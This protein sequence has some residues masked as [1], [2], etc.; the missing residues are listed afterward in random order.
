MQRKER[1]TLPFE[2]GGHADS[3]TGSVARRNRELRFTQIIVAAREAF[4]EDGYAGFTTRGVAGRVGI[5]LGNL[6]YY[7]RTKEELLRAALETYVREILDDYAAI[8]TRPGAVAARRCAA[9]V[10]RFLR[11]INETDLPRFLF[12]IWAFAQH[13]PFAA[14]LIDEWY[15]RY[16]SMFAGLLS[17]IHPSLTSE[18]CLT[19]AAVLVA[20]TNGMAIFAN[21]GAARDKDSAEFARMT[22][23]AVK[24]IVGLS[25]QALE[26]RPAAGRAR[27]RRPAHEGSAYANATDPKGQIEEAQF[28][29]TVRQDG[30]ERLYYR[31][32]VRGR[33]RE[34]KINE[35]VSTAANLLATEG[36]A[37][38]TQARV[39]RELGMLPSALQNY[40]PM[41]EDLLRSTIDAL[42]QVFLDRYA[43]M[44]KPS[45]K[46]ALERLREIVSDV[47]EEALDPQVCRF[48]FEFLAL[49]GHSETTRELVAH[50]YF[51]YRSIYVNLVREI[52]ASAT[53]RECIVRA[54]LIAAQ[55][56]GAATL[57]FGAKSQ[58]PN[59]DR[60]FELMIEMAARI[61]QGAVDAKTAL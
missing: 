11:D 32:T 4:Q 29:L 37:N 12:E 15:A 21:R 50:S 30:Q 55:M 26:S 40:F 3:V 38:F 1:E 16:R 41:H 49:A 47:F 17:E 34:V 48:S 57:M 36:Y 19:R 14:D 18:Q 44:A 8:A 43:E 56:E 58:P 53:A 7:F 24:M 22:K 6:Q 51:T 60:V 42:I 13:E 9:L 35:I 5:T 23:R 10:E 2:G 31:P 45:G 59:V 27:N 25:G 33:R 46:P 54:T 52:D 20:Q 28:Q 39:A 61:A